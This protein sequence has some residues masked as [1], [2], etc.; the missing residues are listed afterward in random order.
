MMITAKNYHLDHSSCR[1]FELKDSKEGE[2]YAFGMVKSKE[3]I[4][5]LEFLRT[6]KFTPYINKVNNYGE[7]MLIVACKH[8]KWANAFSLLEVYGEDTLPSHVDKNGCNAIYYSITREKLVNR[9]L[10]YE[11]VSRS[12]YLSPQG[13][14][15]LMMILNNRL[16][17]DF[18][19]IPLNI[20]DI[21]HVNDRHETAFILAIKNEFYDVANTLL[22]K[23][24]IPYY[25]DETGN[26][27]INYLYYN[28]KDNFHRL[29]LEL[30]FNILSSIKS[31]THH[32]MKLYSIDEILV[33][34]SVCNAE[35]SFGTIKTGLIL[36]N[37]TYVVL[38]KYKT[39]FE[40][41]VNSETINELFFL[42]KFPDNNTVNIYGLYIDDESNIYLVLE[43]LAITLKLYFKVLSFLPDEKEYLSIKN[44]RYNCVFYELEKSLQKIHKQGV[45]HG[46]LK[47]LNIMFDYS[48]HLKILDFGISDFLL[49]NPY[50]HTIM[51]YQTT[52][53]IKAPDY[54]RQMRINILK[55]NKETNKESYEI[56]K[57][58][59]F[60]TSRKSYSSD[61]YSLGVTIIQG[62]LKT[63]DK[64][65]SIDEEIYRV[66]SI[67][68]LPENYKDTKDKIGNINLLKFQT[69][70][71]MGLKF[72]KSLISM[73]S[74]DGKSRGST[75]CKNY[76]HNNYTEYTHDKNTVWSR[77]IHYSCV[78]L[79]KK[80]YEVF[81]SD[82][83]FENYRFMCMNLKNITR[84]HP[85]K[86][87]IDELFKLNNSKYC[88]DT[89]LNTLYWSF[90]YCG[91]EEDRI[92]C[93][94]YFI[95]FSCIFELK[96]FDL[97]DIC[98]I[99]KIPI[100]IFTG[101]LNSRIFNLII[102]IEVIPFSMF[103]GKMTMLLQFHLISSQEIV[104][105]EN[106]LYEKIQEYI[107]L[108]TIT[109]NMYLW[110]F[111]RLWTVNKLKKLPFD[112]TYEDVTI[113]SFF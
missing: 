50:K 60:E 113:L 56:S 21:N 108:G 84:R 27:A 43:P 68:K 105:V 7:T 48:G 31:H 98:T 77:N 25:Y 9:I 51:N 14:T 17:E 79:V 4:K 75:F 11:S 39:S 99:F 47:D 55:T 6:G 76:Y 62:I 18:K 110:D 29:G 91:A 106:L 8:K 35:G 53:Y 30:F 45:L 36:D 15:I 94:A 97:H 20:E 96:T 90:K 10:S 40:E 100:H 19:S 89:Y 93:T 58:Y 78:D 109:T 72:Y 73:I 80:Q 102:N 87:I 1:S 16:H 101:A 28:L 107:T 85:K 103:I 13:D 2:I 64:F 82:E 65:I 86:L 37:N 83:I 42:Q 34:N 57:S 74:I 59:L 32:V 71:L 111:I 22:F 92:I 26:S 49:F 95:I 70:E 54:H 5:F 69:H 12:H 46:D 41:V 81:H 66:V 33:N 112:F 44:E 63:H 61:I 3:K 52:Q 67:S 24:A 38:K 104:I 88:I 23:G